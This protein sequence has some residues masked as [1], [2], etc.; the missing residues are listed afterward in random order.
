MK[1]RN[2]RKGYWI[3]KDIY[4]CPLCGRD[5]S[6]Q[7]RIYDRPKPEHWEDRNKVIDSWDYCD[8]L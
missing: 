6:Y 4:Y 7:E 8:A 2:V 3:L 5:R 1:K